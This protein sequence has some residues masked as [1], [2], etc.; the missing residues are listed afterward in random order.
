MDNTTPETPATTPTE[1]TATVAVEH[2]SDA[3]GTHHAAGPLGDATFYVLIS[4]IAFCLLAYKFGRSSVT[5]GLDAKI[6]HIKNEL[7]AAAQT[8]REAEQMLADA[9][10]RAKQ[11]EAETARIV[12]QAQADAKAMRDTAAQE[13]DADMARRESLLANRLQRM[14]DE[15]QADLQSYAAALVI[16]SAEQI[17]SQAVNEKTHAQ[18]VQ[19]TTESLPQTLKMANSQAA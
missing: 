13:L 1:T 18:L 7:D 19:N 14:Q 9:Q 16:Q 5:S 6:A 3:H 17:V 12:T 4:F 2:A 8:R 15:A 10:T 11:I